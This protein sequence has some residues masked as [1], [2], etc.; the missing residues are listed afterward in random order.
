MAAPAGAKFKNEQSSVL[1]VP[2][3]GEKL[4]L[5]ALDVHFDDRVLVCQGF[6]QRDGW[7]QSNRLWLQTKR[8][9]AA[10]AGFPAASLRSLEIGKRYARLR[11]KFLEPAGEGHVGGLFEALSL[12]VPPGPSRRLRKQGGVV[13]QKVRPEEHPEAQSQSSPLARVRKFESLEI[14]SLKPREF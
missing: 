5:G 11:I 3:P 6:A 4:K 2:R 7:H 8:L 13:L 10:R 12:G 14:E 9:T 1:P